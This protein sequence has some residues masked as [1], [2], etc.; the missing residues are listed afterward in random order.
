VATTRPKRPAGA[1]GEWSEEKPIRR[2]NAE[3]GRWEPTGKTR[4]IWKVSRTEPWTSTD[5][6]GVARSG[7]KSIVA[8]GKDLTTAHRNLERRLRAFREMQNP[9]G[10]MREQKITLTLS[11]YFWETWVESKRFK[12]YKGNSA[13]NHVTRMRLHALPILG[14]KRL[15]DLDRDDIRHLFDVVLPEKTIESG[16][17]KGGK[18][19]SEQTRDIWKTLHVVLQDA[20]YDRKLMRNPMLDIRDTDKPKRG[21]DRADLAIPSGIVVALTQ[22]L[23]QT[24]WEVEEVRWMLAVLTGV[25]GGEALGLTWDRVSGVVDGDTRPARFTIAQQYDRKDVPHGPGCRSGKDGKWACGQQARNCPRHI[26]KPESGYVI[27]PWTKSQKP[28]TPPLTRRMRRLLRLQ[29]DRQQAWR[30]ENPAAWEQQNAKRPDLAGLVFTDQMGR[31]FRRQDDGKRWHEL[32]DAAGYPDFDVSAH[33]T[34]HIAVTAMAIENIPLAVVGE[35]VGHSSEDITR[36]YTHARGE[37]ARQYLEAIDERYDAEEQAAENVRL[38][39]QMSLIHEAQERSRAEEEAAVRAWRDARTVGDAI[40]YDPRLHPA[41]PDGAWEVA[42]LPEEL[43]AVLDQPYI[44]PDAV[45]LFTGDLTLDEVA[46][47]APMGA[48]DPALVRRVI[49]EGIA[50]AFAAELLKS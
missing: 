28:R 9:T 22:T 29:W 25:R 4:V 21:D 11:E 2:F 42:W 16:R 20:V 14:E 10:P 36:V 48:T 38:V 44:T 43:R 6:N 40:S 15:I 27:V 17:N 39:A 23:R 3:S 7:S 41:P 13:R 37:D 8:E 49:D 35:I 26:E 12:T 1:G 32:L 34:R 46:K 5:E 31:P 19:G 47:Y 50:D 30:A 24:E 45:N 33:K 18:Y